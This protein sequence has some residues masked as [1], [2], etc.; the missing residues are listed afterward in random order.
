MLDCTVRTKEVRR[1]CSHQNVCTD[2]ADGKQTLEAFSP[3]PCCCT[4]N[5]GACVQT[6]VLISNEC[7]RYGLTNAGRNQNVI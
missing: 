4:G 1:S 2:V 7:S 6:V 3:Q 5:V